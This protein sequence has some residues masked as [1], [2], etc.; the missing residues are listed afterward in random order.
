MEGGQEWV[1]SRDVAHGG[2]GHVPHAT[3]LQ[4]PG[5]SRRRHAGRH[6]VPTAAALGHA[7]ERAGIRTR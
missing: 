5:C 6:A 7:Q 1:R 3:A 4:L 2:P